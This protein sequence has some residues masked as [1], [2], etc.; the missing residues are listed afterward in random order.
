MSTLPASE[1]P[2]APR[3]ARKFLLWAIFA[4]VV[5]AIAIT[6]T[7]WRRA[8]VLPVPGSPEYTKMVRAFYTG[9]IAMQVGDDKRALSE[10]E[11]AT[12]IVPPEP[13]AH[14]NL[15][16]LALRARDFPTAKTH[17][18]KAHELA[19]NNAQ[20]EALL[21]AWEK[22][23]GNFD[24]AIAHLQRAIELD[25]NDLRARYELTKIIAQVGAAD[26]DTQIK[27]Q[28]D[29]ILKTQPDNLTALLDQAR[30]AA[31]NNDAQTLKNVLEKL[32]ANS[33]G[34]PMEA[35]EQLKELQTAPINQ[36]T[37]PAI[38]L[39]NLL[40]ALPAY[41]S[42][43]QVLA[44][45]GNAVADPIENFL[46]LQIPSSQPAPPD[47]Q[48]TFTA[49]TLIG[50]A[51]ANFEGARALIADE[52]SAP[53]AVF[54]DNRSLQIYQKSKPILLP[55][56][57]AK[58]LAILDWNA[59]FQNDLLV[60]GKNGLNFYQNKGGKFVN[61]T[62]QTYAGNS[63]QEFGLNYQGAW[64]AD[65]EAD[66]DLD[67]ILSRP[68][69][70]SLELRNNGDGWSWR[71]QQIFTPVKDVR[72]FVW[73]DFDGDND[74][75]AA[76]IDGAGALHFFTNNR[77]G[78]FSERKDVPKIGATAAIAVSDLDSDGTFDLIVWQRDGGLVR[79]WLKD[80]QWLQAS[81]GKMAV[82][83]SFAVARVLCAD[84]DNNGAPDILASVDN[85]TQIWLG[86]IGTNLNAPLQIAGTV[87]DV[88]DV[89]QD[90]RID[91]LGVENGKA[92]QWIN[93]GV[94]NYHWQEILPQATEAQGDKRINSFGIGGEMELRVGTI[95]QKQMI[96]APRVHFGLG[97]NNTSDALRL[98][99]PNGDAQGEFELK[100]DQTIVA[101]QRLTGS[102]PYLFVWDGTQMRFVKDVNWRS[103][104]G[105]KINSQDTA[106]IVQTEDWAHIR[107]DQMQAK[108]GKYDVRITADLWE[109]DY[110]DTIQLLT[111]DHPKNTRV[112][113]DERFSI[114]MPPLRVLTT[115]I[116]QPLARVLDTKQ[117][118]VSATLDDLDA[119]YLDCGRGQYQ[120][121]TRDHWI[122]GELPASAPRDKPLWL[123]AQGWL[124]PTD[125]SVNVALAQNGIV[126]QDLSLEV[127]DGRGGWRVAQ[128]HLGFPAGKNKAITIDLSRAFVANAPRRF[129]LRTNLEIYWDKVS[130]AVGLN[131]A[132]TKI[133][134]LLPE[135]AQLRYRG[136]SKIVAK[137]AASPEL[138]TSYQPEA[139]TMARWHDLP[140]FYTRFGDVRPLLERIDDRYVIMNAGDEMRLQFAAPP[141]PTNG[142]TRDWVFISDGWTKDGNMNT[143]FSQTLLPLPAHNLAQT[144][145]PPTTLQNDPVYQKHRDDWR[146]YHT[147]WVDSRKFQ[148]ALRAGLN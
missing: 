37:T 133:E 1:Q 44:P 56:K 40:H 130:W 68:N 67:M 88:A 141:A 30:L 29:A 28:L 4:V 72:A 121:V 50:S 15:G 76:L 66:G 129:R 110:F 132:Q 59:D 107:G 126:P 2:A 63:S 99:W 94:K 108:N 7:L 47:T 43:L 142:Q 103:P 55:M 131:N 139:G 124:H 101:E 134:R 11:N 61:V 100:A 123:I 27:T 80:N 83:Q 92:T 112:W 8:N 70:T 105:L 60:A 58:A 96:S 20:I 98:T 21:G 136:F 135:T 81:L 91:L 16:V 48:L 104:L 89:N 33:K 6:G 19:P 137:N 117:R 42:A 32:E 38:Y 119:D 106:G 122:E 52:K 35:R 114:P 145:V 18:D 102:C 113:V 23:Q 9:V 34:W 90:G 25:T 93:K 24:G 84:F 125:S 86:D 53:L 147:R 71:G 41:Q 95:Y 118:D 54:H 74:N 62:G 109:A 46:V 82:P 144:A 148:G 5:I 79:L 26:A 69:Q 75:D 3:T 12:T 39:A 31:K 85:Q 87:F 97:E 78:Q 65:I 143:T 73:S 45:A 140:G 57:N 111:V 115:T 49:T 127:A 138:P 51:N 128:A 22:A 120:G 146:G 77:S 116:D 14:A 10:L 36:A 13:A 64:V 17:L